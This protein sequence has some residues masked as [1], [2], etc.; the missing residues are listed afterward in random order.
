MV[1]G[2]FPSMCHRIEELLEKENV[3]LIF[4]LVLVVLHSV[5]KQVQKTFSNPQSF[6]SLRGI[7][8]DGDD[9]CKKPTL[10]D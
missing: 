2:L 8:E 10:S 4:Y 5:N 7:H 9:R 6:Y 1:Q 3:E